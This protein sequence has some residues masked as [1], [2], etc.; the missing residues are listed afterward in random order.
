MQQYLHF[1][2]NVAITDHYLTW[3][4]ITDI[5]TNILYSISILIYIFNEPK[6][7]GKKWTYAFILSNSLFPKIMY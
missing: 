7:K 1:S 4:L 3:K 5:L 2:E 6:T